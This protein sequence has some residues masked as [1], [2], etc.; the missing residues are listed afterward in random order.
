MKSPIVVLPFSLQF[1][2]RGMGGVAEGAP[3]PT[4]L[5]PNPPAK[6]TNFSTPGIQAIAK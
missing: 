6:G 2:P 1:P 5:S 3:P 4:A